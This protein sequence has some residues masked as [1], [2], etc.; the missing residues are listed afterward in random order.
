MDTL[1]LVSTAV[2]G[3]ATFV[4]QDRVAKKAEAAA[5]E[6]AHARVEH[7]RERE[8]AALQLERV[9]SQMGDVYRPVQAMMNQAE[10]CAVYM[11]RELGF[12][13]N[14]IWGFEFVRPF[15]LWPHIEVLTRDYSPK[16]FAALKGS[17]YKNYS[18]ADIAL[19][20]DPAKRQLYIEAHA[21]CIAPRCREIAT[22]LSTKTA[23][24]PQQNDMQHW[25]KTCCKAIGLITKSVFVRP[26]CFFMHFTMILA[27]RLRSSNFW[28]R[29]R[30]RSSAFV[31][32]IVL[33]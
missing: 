6:L 1:A 31:E 15:A 10:S 9:R 27:S 8:L 20:E 26:L 32:M 3:I 12:E 30:A 14:E 25:S 17:P 33:L 5:K 24:T 11:Q 21:S 13:F 29:S 18:T 2:L 7:E 23:S 16:M 28:L 22:I 19:P 4:L